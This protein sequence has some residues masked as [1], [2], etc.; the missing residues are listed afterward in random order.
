MKGKYYTTAVCHTLNSLFWV[1][2]CVHIINYGYM[3]YFKSW[4]T[5]NGQKAQNSWCLTRQKSNTT[6]TSARSAESSVQKRSIHFNN[7]ASHFSSQ[8]EIKCSTTRDESIFEV[9]VF[10][11]FAY[12][13][14][15]QNWC[16]QFNQMIYNQ[17]RARILPS[18]WSNSNQQWFSNTSHPV[19]VTVL[20][21]I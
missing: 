2:K 7:L 6:E 1:Q 16:W 15:M 5:R 11:W 9:Y 10:F 19:I 8:H 4:C 14:Q 20:F 18:S 21:L 3:K 17:G 12:I 13:N